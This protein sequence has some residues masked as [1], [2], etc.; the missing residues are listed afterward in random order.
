MN[1]VLLEQTAT[2]LTRQTLRWDRRLRLAT[3][4]VW[5]PRGLMVGLLVG[6]VVAVISRLRL[7]L[8]PEQ[9]AQI[10]VAA[11]MCCGAGLLALIWLWPRSK[12]HRARYF[13]Y[14]LGLKERIS[15]ALELSGGLIPLPA[16]LAERQLTD[17]VNAARRVDLTAHLPLRIHWREILAVLAL[18]VLLAFLLIADN[19]LNKEL[20][21][22]RELKNAINSQAE[23]LEDTIQQIEQNP[24]L[25]AE[26]KD[27]LTQP[28]QEAL[29]ILRQPDVSQEE[30]VAALAEASQSL[31][32]LSDGMSSEQKSAYQRAADQLGG[33]DPAREMAQALRKPNLSE[34]A[35][36][37]DNL[38]DN[39]GENGLSQQQQQNLADQLEAAAD[40]LQQS[41]PAMAEKLREAAEALREGDTEA[42]Q[43]A[44]REAAEMARQQ[45]EQ[46]KDSPMAQTAQDTA[47]QMNG[48]QRNLSMAGQ[49]TTPQSSEGAQSQ[50]QTGQQQANQDQESGQSSQSE[51][52]QSGSG[53]PQSSEPSQSQP[54]TQGEG[55][56]VPQGAG[57]GQTEGESQPPPDNSSSSQSGGQ[58]GENN[59]TSSQ[60]S[61]GQATGGSQ[62]QQGSALTAGS[63]EGGAGIDTTTG[64]V[65]EPGSGEISTDNTSQSGGGL[66]GYNPAN[67]SSTI[68]GESD[69]V[70]DIGG[71]GTPQEGDVIREGEFGP[72]PE[73]ES[74]LSYT[75]VYGAYQ[76]IVSEALESGRIPL[77][78][79]DV[80]HDYFS[81]L[82]R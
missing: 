39:L 76:G 26:E 40:E 54:G 61:Q 58:P 1:A 68:G 41:D 71:E 14:R 53:P 44:L 10:A 19:P 57:A 78:Q 15:T 23:Q 28:L 82:D 8:L 35:D 33:S 51:E 24:A 48:S 11:L 73:G 18:A 55:E 7:W 75:G 65:V 37:T 2:Q 16:Q 32:D 13:D 45:Q 64:S 31:Q 20:R 66:Q 36:A 17:A 5:V 74:T 72:N 21:A 77:D 27:A 59:E 38:A 79:R 60:T 67:D 56:M 34:T 3:S 70:I 4:L 49:Q 9:I 62:P 42:A 30:A 50:D 6:I 29:D 12:T 81:S 46:L 52:G 43:E 80:I 47:Q 63:G 22:Q 69:Q 25:S